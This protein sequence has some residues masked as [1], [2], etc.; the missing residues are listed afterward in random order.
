MRRSLHEGTREILRRLEG[1]E[2]RLEEIEQ[3]RGGA[4][5]EER[6]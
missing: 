4:P 2:R 6:S 1:I 5:R 3:K